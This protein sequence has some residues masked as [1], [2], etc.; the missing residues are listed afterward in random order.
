MKA[1]GDNMLLCERGSVVAEINAPADRIISFSTAEQ[2]TLPVVLR[3][4]DET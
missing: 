1:K 4:T 3:L 2:I